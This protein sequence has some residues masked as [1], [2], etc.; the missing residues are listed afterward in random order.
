M[1]IQLFVPMMTIIKTVQ[2]AEM[3]LSYNIDYCNV[4]MFSIHEYININ[5]FT[6]T[7]RQ[8][9]ISLFQEPVKEK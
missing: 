2:L 6:H 4:S 3:A 9:Y 7:N 8:L 5:I 1:N